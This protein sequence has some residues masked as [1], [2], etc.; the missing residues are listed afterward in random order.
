M[1]ADP[2]D[3]VV[4]FG[5]P[6]PPPA[7]T[8]L[9]SRLAA[10][11]DLDI[12]AQ[13]SF[14]HGA[15][16][17]G[18]QNWYDRIRAMSAA[19]PLQEP[20]QPAGPG[21]SAIGAARLAGEN[22]LPS[23]FGTAGKD[24]YAKALEE[25]RAESEFIQ[26][27]H[28]GAYGAGELAGGVGTGLALPMAEP[29]ALARGGSTIANA[30]RTLGNL[31][32]TGAAYG[33]INA[34]G[35]AH[36]SADMPG[37]A[38]EGALTGG[39]TTAALG[40]TLGAGGGLLAKLFGPTSGHLGATFRPEAAGEAMV[41]NKLQQGGTDP[42]ALAQK[43]ADMHAANRTDY[44]LAD[45]APD[46][47]G[48][49]AG[50]I[51]RQPGE[52][53]AA[54]RSFLNER[55]FGNALDTGARVRNDQALADF[56]GSDGIRAKENEIEARQKAAAAPLYDAAN[57]DPIEMNA[58]LAGLIPRLQAAGAYKDA[59]RR[60]AEAGTGPS[61]GPLNLNT[62]E[63]WQRMKED[64]DATISARQASGDRGGARTATI[65][66]NQLTDELYNQSPNYQ[67]ANA[68]WKSDADMK[69][70]LELGRK[71]ANP[72][73]TREQLTSDFN[74]LS[75]GEQNMFRLGASNALREKLA[76]AP[77]TGNLPAAV[78]GGTALGQKLKIIAPDEDSH[79][80][81]TQR[82]QA[83]AD[84]ARTKYAA[85]GNSQSIEK[86]TAD[87]ENTSSLGDVGKTFQMA[88]ALAFGHPH[89][90]IR[91]VGR[92]AKEI[93]PNLRGGV[94]NEARKIILNP[95][96]GAVDKFAAK[97]HDMGMPSESASKILGLVSRSPQSLQGVPNAS[98]RAMTPAEMQQN[99]P[100]QKNAEP[101]APATWKLI[102]RQSDGQT[103]LHNPATGEMQPYAAGQ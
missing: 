66:K 85:M 29:F 52:G 54:A 41:A 45:A 53:R 4:D 39:P 24:A 26:K 49:L 31:G 98:I 76:V 36:T 68:A 88:G 72:S 40:G 46:Q 67:Q 62:L 90:I 10:L 93:D 74:A 3:D 73:Y 78:T 43:V 37:A 16:Q 27:A 32:A 81:F 95:D 7:A 97:L 13:F 86:A 6:A 22:L 77:G 99:E 84:M 83:E 42:Q 25:A 1:T 58:T 11:K 44:T 2:W 79:A 65:L 14:L 94:L 103:F 47:L 100:D 71:T 30:A 21:N 35:G 102:R 17:G 69:D 50:T 56:L 101:T 82:M 20:G 51:S 12:P 80:L 9:K 15:A 18:S 64:L 19:S 60:M 38:V 70:A 63:P 23:V 96:P 89:Q 59:S 48:G 34:A 92:Y 33:A 8:P 55:Q 87:I 57:K 5:A 61:R 91:E 28:P 75:P